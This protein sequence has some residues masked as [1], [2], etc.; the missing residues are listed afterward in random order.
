[1]TLGV[2]GFMLDC[3]MRKR[4]DNGRDNHVVEE[5]HDASDISVKIDGEIK[6]SNEHKGSV[7]VSHMY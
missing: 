1:M 6:W 5:W 2:N 3:S 7:T 4:K